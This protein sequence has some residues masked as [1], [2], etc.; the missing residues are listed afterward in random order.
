M[1]LKKMT[2][3]AYS[4][5]TFTKKTG[6]KYAVLIN[7]DTYTHSYSIQY[8]NQ[9]PPGSNGT[10]TV[11]DKMGEETVSCKITFDGTGVIPDSP[12]AKGGS[13]SVKDQIN[14]FRQIVFQYSGEQHRPKFVMLKWGTLL[15]KCQ[16]K[17]LT[18]RYTLFTP[19]GQPVR[20]EA[21][22]VFAGYNNV[23][24]KKKEK[25]DSSPDMSHLVTVK[26]GDTLPLLCYRI[27]GTSL[28]YAEVA[29]VN[30]LTGFRRIEPGMQL[31]FPPLGRS[32]A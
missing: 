11:F 16:L 9:T 21:D 13:S 1:G 28:P 19:D 12:A 3:V 27:Y 18:L 14:S 20:A 24:E 10:F 29:R 22:V 2:L 6:D 32:P 25:N 4:D 15:F 30:G 7:P 17:T 23:A 8:D 26:A 31:L 5:G